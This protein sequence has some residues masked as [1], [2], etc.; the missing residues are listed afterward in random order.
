VADAGSISLACAL[1]YFDWRKQID[2]RKDYPALIDWLEHFRA[3]FP[4]FDETKAEH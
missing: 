2:W 1:G 4:A 3:A